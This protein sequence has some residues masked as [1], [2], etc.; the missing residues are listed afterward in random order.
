MVREGWTGERGG[1]GRREWKKGFVVEWNQWKL[2]AEGVDFPLSFCLFLICWV[3]LLFLHIH[4]HN[5]DAKTNI[6]NPYSTQQFIVISD[7]WYCHAR[8]SQDKKRFVCFA[9]GIFGD[10]EQKKEINII[11]H[12]RSLLK[13]KFNPNSNQQAKRRHPSPHTAHCRNRMDKYHILVAELMCVLC[14]QPQKPHFFERDCVNDKYFFC[15]LHFFFFF[16]L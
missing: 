2:N 13:T 9:M 1:K 6:E 5:D 10:A 3:F 11:F 7:S 4:S 12:S 15:G 14:S 8:E 16:F